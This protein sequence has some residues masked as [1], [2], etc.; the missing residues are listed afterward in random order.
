V[1]WLDASSN[2]TGFTV[3]SATVTGGVV[4]NFGNVGTVAAG[5]QTFVD[6]TV[7]TGRIYQYQVRANGVAGNSAYV[8]ATSQ[9]TAP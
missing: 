8:P 5:V 3:Q 1:N 6:R 2:E 4:G 9:V 7:R